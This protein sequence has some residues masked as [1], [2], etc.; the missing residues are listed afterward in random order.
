[1]MTLNYI[2][3]LARD[4]NFDFYSPVVEDYHMMLNY[5]FRATLEY[6]LAGFP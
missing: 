2:W 5:K 3:K 1:M 4:Q 6:L